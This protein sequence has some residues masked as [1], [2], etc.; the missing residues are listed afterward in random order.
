MKRMSNEMIVLRGVG[1]TIKQLGKAF[2]GLEQTFVVALTLF[3][4]GV[5][6]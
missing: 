6:S 3:V 1:L 2:F 5:F 4:S